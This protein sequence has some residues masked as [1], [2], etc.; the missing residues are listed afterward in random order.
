M[1]VSPEYQEYVTEQLAT[2]GYIVAK[3]MFGGVGLYAD[4]IFFALLA[5]D[6]LYLKVDDANRHDYE[7][8]GMDAFRP[9]PDKSRVMQYYEVPVEVLEDQEELHKWSMKSVA[10]ALKTR[11]K[12]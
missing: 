4:G 9:Y 8:A 3:R 12:K 7:L 5:D 10:A 2:V 1:S 6:V 11:K